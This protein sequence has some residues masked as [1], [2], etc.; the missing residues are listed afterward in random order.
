MNFRNTNNYLI[1]ELLLAVVSLVFALFTVLFDSN[2]FNSANIY[3]MILMLIIISM[4]MFFY[5]LL[6][7]KRINPKQYIYVSY[8]Y[9]D[10]DTKELIVKEL[11][12]KLGRISKYRFE[13]LTVDSIP[14]GA[15]M[16]KTMQEYLQKSNITIIIVSQKYILN[17]WCNREFIEISGMN[18]KI[19]PIVIDTYEYLTELPK[20]ISNIKALCIC[21]DK[22][23]ENIGKQMDLLAKDLVRQRKD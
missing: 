19:I 10:R 9:D 13:I 11:E 6:I 22:L 15:D 18:K 21:S 14:Y 1:I 2:K 8:S 23:A 4:V 20:D 5:L 3:L 7:V 12:E 17:E 16:Q